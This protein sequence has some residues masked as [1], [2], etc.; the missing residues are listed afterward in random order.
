MKDLLRQV[1]DVCLSDVVVIHRNFVKEK[2][3]TFVGGDFSL[4]VI[5]FCKKIIYFRHG[6]NAALQTFFTALELKVNDS[7]LTIF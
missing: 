2:V 7:P 1:V 3:R 5:K 4:K 6:Q